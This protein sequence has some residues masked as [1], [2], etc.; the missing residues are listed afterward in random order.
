M[1]E[2]GRQVDRDKMR[3]N[4]GCRWLFGCRFVSVVA[5]PRVIGDSFR[6]PVSRLKS[7]SGGR[8]LTVWFGQTEPS[9]RNGKRMSFQEGMELDFEWF[10]FIPPFCL[11]S[12]L[13]V[14]DFRKAWFWLKFA[15]KRR[16]KFKSNSLVAFC[17]IHIVTHSHAIES[18][19]HFPIFPI[20]IDV[21]GVTINPHF[22]NCI[23]FP[24]TMLSHVPVWQS[25]IECYSPKK[26]ALFPIKDVPGYGPRTPRSHPQPSENGEHAT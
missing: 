22:Q 7:F 21:V 4:A 25:S 6:V 13:L 14:H 1:C 20:A 17:P 10:F 26:T 11:R 2:N 18:E 19:V 12:L 16:G 15:P 5:A 3:L 23:N 8:W 24:P 9:W